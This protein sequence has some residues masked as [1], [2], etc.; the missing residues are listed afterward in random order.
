MPRART[1]VRID[2]PTADRITDAA[3]E[4]GIRAATLD[5]QAITVDLLSQPGSGRLYRKGKGTVHRASAPG[6]PP[7]P[8][9]GRLRQAAATGAEVIGTTGIVSVNTEYAAALEYG[10]ERM[11][12]RPFLSRLPE[13]AQR[14]IAVFSANARD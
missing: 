5:A 13:Y 3:L 9:T 2:L 11:A 14:L 1:V 12:P 6:E 7:A 8:N 10:T 4:R